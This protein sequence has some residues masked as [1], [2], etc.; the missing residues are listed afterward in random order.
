MKQNLNKEPI[1]L[2]DD[3]KNLILEIISGDNAKMIQ[4]GSCG[5]RALSQ[6]VPNTSEGASEK[7]LPVIETNGTHV[8]VKVGSI[9]HPMGEEHSI[10]WVCLVSKAGCIQRVYLTPDC[11]PVAEFVLME[12]D[13]PKAAYAYC[14]LHGFWKTEA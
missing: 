3:E 14:N 11:E 8:T 5:S 9:F 6:L 12:G 4:D 7:H 2:T 1:F 10:V 13:A